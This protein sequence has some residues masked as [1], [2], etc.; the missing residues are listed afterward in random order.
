MRCLRLFMAGLCVGMATLLPLPALAAASLAELQSLQDGGYRITSQLFMYT[1]LEK[2]GERRKDV[3]RLIAVLEPRVA[4][5]NDK[6][7]TATWQALRSSVSTDP[8]VNGEVSQQA[9]YVIEDNATRFAQALEHLIPHDADP[10]KMAVHDLVKRMHVMM[11]IYLRN[12]ADPIGG[13]NYSGINRELDLEKLP[14]EFSAKLAVLEKSQPAM[15]P[16]IAKI[17]PKWAFLSPRIS[18]YNQKSVPYLVDIYGRQ[19]IDQLMASAPN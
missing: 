13:A 2:A 10:K 12:S 19:I 11:T 6:D 17:R 5:L 14:G 3:N 7:V 16:V 18:D 4:A 1:I 9:L 15:A 8:Y